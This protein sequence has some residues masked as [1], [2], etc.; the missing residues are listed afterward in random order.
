M[1]DFLNASIVSVVVAVDA[2]ARSSFVHRARVLV[3]VR[4]R[5]RDRWTDDGDDDDGGSSFVFSRVDFKRRGRT[6]TPRR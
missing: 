3:F 2:R 1:R 6:P 5:R 4:V